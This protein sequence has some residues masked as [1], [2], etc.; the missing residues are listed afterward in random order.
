MIKVT[1]KG[2]EVR[3][4]VDGVVGPSCSDLTEKLEQAIGGTVTSIELKEEYEQQEAGQLTLR[5]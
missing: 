5:Q 3:I 1:V 4:E 2:E